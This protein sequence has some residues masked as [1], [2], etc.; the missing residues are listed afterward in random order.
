MILTSTPGQ[1]E[2]QFF[3]QKQIDQKFSGPFIDRMSTLRQ[4]AT[5]RKRTTNLFSHRST[6]VQYLYRGC[7]FHLFVDENINFVIAV[8]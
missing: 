3:D 6:I 5:A 7:P 8:I 4:P 1:L 2:R